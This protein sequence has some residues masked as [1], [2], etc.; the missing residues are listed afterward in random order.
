LL[1]KNHSTC[2]G[3][4]YDDPAP[5]SSPLTSV[6]DGIAGDVE[7]DV[8]RLDADLI[9]IARQQA[10]AIAEQNERERITRARLADLRGSRL[11]SRRLTT[12]L[13]RAIA[14]RRTATTRLD[15]IRDWSRHLRSA[16]LALKE[17]SALLAEAAAGWRRSPRIRAGVRAYREDDFLAANPLRATHG[18]QPAT[19][20]G[21]MVGHR[22]RRD[23]DDP[24]GDVLQ[25]A[26]A[27]QI[28]YL[29]RTTEIFAAYRGGLPRRGTI[30]LLGTGFTPR[31]AQELLASVVT[32]M[33][34]PNSLILVAEVVAAAQ[35]TLGHPL[36]AGGGTQPPRVSARQ[37][38]LS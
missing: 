5:P 14:D 15:S 1:T 34:E 29:P 16:V 27:W 4:D 21:V 2:Q 9:R 13:N 25:R 28:G 35:R 12:E 38:R 8:L 22:W 20:D 3:H 30:W 32:R 19:L 10:T 18:V 24:P 11:N 33:Q 7:F 26:G 37:S 17:P 23:G 6:R 36:P 31:H